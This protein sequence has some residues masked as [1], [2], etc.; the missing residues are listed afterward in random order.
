M[1]NNVA[2]NIAILASLI[3]ESKELLIKGLKIQSNAVTIIIIKVIF[4]ST[5]IGPIS[6]DSDLKIFFFYFFIITN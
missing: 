2:P 5:V 3:E 1:K 4:S 6:C